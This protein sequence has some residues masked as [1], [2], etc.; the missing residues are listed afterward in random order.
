MSGPAMSGAGSDG[1]WAERP[2]S[3]HCMFMHT[4]EPA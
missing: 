4:E 3:L 1:M 2:Y